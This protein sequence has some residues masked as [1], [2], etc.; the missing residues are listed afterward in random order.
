MGRRLGKVREGSDLDKKVWE[1]GDGRTRNVK[2]MSL[3]HLINVYHY[4][5]RACVFMEVEK[6]MPKQAELWKEWRQ[7]FR[8]ELDR[9][10]VEY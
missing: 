8:K 10:N 1:S 9:R 5:G 3:P 6:D 2:E 7:V 4:S